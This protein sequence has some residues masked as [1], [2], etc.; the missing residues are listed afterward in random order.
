MLGSQKWKLPIARAAPNGLRGYFFYKISLF[1]AIKKKE[2][3]GHIK[4][5]VSPCFKN[6]V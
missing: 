4:N 6:I 5:P 3:K 1:L 2:L